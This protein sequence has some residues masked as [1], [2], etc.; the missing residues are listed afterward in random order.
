MSFRPFRDM[1]RQ[2]ASITNRVDGL[3]TAARPYVDPDDFRSAVAALTQRLDG[4]VAVMD[5]QDRA[6]ENVA[7]NQST[8][9]QD[10]LTLQT[11]QKE[12]IHAVAEGIERTDR[13]ERRIR[14]VVKRARQELKKRG[15]EDAGLEAEDL[16]FRDV[17][18][19]G[20]GSDRLLD[21]QSP[22]EEAGNAASSVAGVS[23]DTLRRAR[24]L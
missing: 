23:I 1:A 20:S 19:N 8:I 3:E 9:A 16:Q 22:V 17:D 12:L 11:S 4:L 15:Y 13:A 2:L 24:G 6:V 18:E 5:N 21:V 10:L 14:A 7:V